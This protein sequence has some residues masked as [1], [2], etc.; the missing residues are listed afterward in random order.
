MQLRTVPQLEFKFDASI[1]RGAK[2]SQLID[3]AVG[4]APKV[5][6]EQ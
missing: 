5:R 4:N 1:E 2:L 3:E 6:Q